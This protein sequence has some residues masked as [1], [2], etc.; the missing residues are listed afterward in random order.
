MTDCN[1][2]PLV[3]VLL[4]KGM[5]VRELARKVKVSE[6]QMWR[7]IRGEREPS[8]AKAGDIALAMGIDWEEV[9]RLCKEGKNSDQSGTAEGA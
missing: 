7:Y 3:K 6:V 4:E 1:S 8:I 9:L 2:L 5:S